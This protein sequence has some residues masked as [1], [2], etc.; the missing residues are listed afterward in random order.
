MGSSQP[1][2]MFASA[3]YFSLCQYLTLFHS[4]NYGY[5]I[6]IMDSLFLRG[7]KRQLTEDEP[8]EI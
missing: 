7:S 3:I 2:A 5:L 6:R 1:S 4:I 8:A